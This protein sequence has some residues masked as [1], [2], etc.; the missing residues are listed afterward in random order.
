MA[1]N[2]T[3]QRKKEEQEPQI[4]PIAIGIGATGQRNDACPFRSTVSCT[5]GS[6]GTIWKTNVSERRTAPQPTD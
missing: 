6:M 3:A 2:V 5:A 4:L 1:A